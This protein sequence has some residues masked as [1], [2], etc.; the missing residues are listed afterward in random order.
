MKDERYAL[1]TLVY[2][3]SPYKGIP[4]ELKDKFT[5][6]GKIPI[7]DWYLDGTKDIGSVGEDVWT[8]EYIHSHCDRF[9]V[10]KIENNLEGESPYGHEV[11]VNIL[12]ALKDYEVSNKRVAVVGS[13]VPWIEAML[14]N[15]GNDVTTI[16]YNVPTT[17][18]KNLQCKDYFDYF[19]S[20]EDQFDTIVSFS[21]IEHSGLGRYGDPLDPDGDIHTVDIIE[22]NLKDE[23]TFIW[24]SPVGWDTLVWNAH[25]VYGPIRMPILFRNFI[26]Q[27]WYGTPSEQ[28]F[29]GSPAAQ[30]NGYQP[31]VVFK[32]RNVCE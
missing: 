28:L 26:K 17:K 19:I 20:N 18:Y 24:G 12:Q 11:V 30:I 13:L 3:Q 16:E 23:G 29:K 15:L 8:D 27:Q 31:V 14:I 6:D 9:T 21:S 25:R 2:N 7:R 22:K 4:V 1:N 5:M 10:D 32:K